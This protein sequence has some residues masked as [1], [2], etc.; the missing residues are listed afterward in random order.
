MDCNSLT[1]PTCCHVLRTTGITVGFITRASGIDWASTCGA[2]G[3]SIMAF[4]SVCTK[5]CN[6]A[7][8]LVPTAGASACGLL[9]LLLLLVVPSLAPTRMPM[10]KSNSG[11]AAAAANGC[12]TNSVRRWLPSSLAVELSIAASDA[13]GSL[14]LSG[15]RPWLA[16]LG[17]RESDLCCS[18]PGP[19]LAASFAACGLLEVRSS[20][21]PGDLTTERSKARCSATL[22]IN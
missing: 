14:F 22:L 19:V 16:P 4:M 3:P 21:A 5:L 11:P 15:C 17:P 2:C 7:S 8:R 18:M 9:L 1:D 20:A 6:S 10:R 13:K 12:A